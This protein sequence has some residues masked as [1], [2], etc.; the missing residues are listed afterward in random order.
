VE[1][2][3]GTLRQECL[4]HLIVLHAQHLAAVLRELLAYHNQDTRIGRLTADP[5]GDAA[6]GNRC[7]PV[8]TSA[9]WA[10][11]LRGARCLS[12]VADGEWVQP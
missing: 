1:R 9:Q 8:A 7:N 4:D 12:S 6:A 3:I 10:P 5:G 11:P 2:V